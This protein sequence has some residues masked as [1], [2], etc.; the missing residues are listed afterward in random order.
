MLP[1]RLKV[2]KS[3]ETGRNNS[4]KIEILCPVMPLVVLEDFVTFLLSNQEDALVYGTLMPFVRFDPRLNFLLIHPAFL[5]LGI[6]GCYNL[7]LF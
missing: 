6:T 3:R 7:L 5:I 2:V 4:E 1:Q